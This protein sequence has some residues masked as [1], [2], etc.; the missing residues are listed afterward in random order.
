MNPG[1]YGEGMNNPVVDSGS[2]PTGGVCD[3]SFAPVREAFT[4]NF[5]ELGEPGAAIALFV[6]GRLVV[7]LWGGR[8]DRARCEPWQRETLVSFFSVGEALTA[9]CA[10]RVVEKGLID[11]D[12]PLAH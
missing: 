6:E 9:L 12:Q 4:R 2:L 1:V 5:T 11:L 3:E 7:D 10:L 8:R